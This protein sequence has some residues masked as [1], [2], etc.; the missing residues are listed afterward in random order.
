MS[1]SSISPGLHRSLLKKYMDFISLEEGD[2][3]LDV[4][5]LTEEEQDELE[6]I[7]HEII[8]ENIEDQL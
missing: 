5:D 7:A 3:F 2:F 8:M 1:T 6:T 4:P